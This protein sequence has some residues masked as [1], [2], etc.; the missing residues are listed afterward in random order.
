MFNNALFFY[1]FA[2][3]RL[4]C[5]SDVIYECNGFLRGIANNWN[6]IYIGQSTN[7][8]PF[9]YSKKLSC[10]ID[11]GIHCFYFSTKTSKFFVLPEDI[12]PYS[13]IFPI[14]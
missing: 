1:D 8:H 2:N 6:S 4:F 5:N 10:S 7:H 14:I 3:G 13:V 11:S 12:D 9:Y